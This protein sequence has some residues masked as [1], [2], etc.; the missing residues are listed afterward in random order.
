MR[1]WKNVL[2]VGEFPNV[3][4]R[5]FE[6]IMWDALSNVA[7]E[8]L[9]MGFGGFAA[10]G[11]ALS[12]LPRTRFMQ[13]K[14]LESALTN[15]CI[16]RREKEKQ[17]VHISSHFRA[18]PMK[19]IFKIELIT[20]LFPFSEMAIGKSTATSAEQFPVVKE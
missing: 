12:F 5:N 10:V 20:M 13:I 6:R 2:F 3:C 18:L 19:G 1:V 15:R 8:Q 16:H 9:K 14:R 4:K 7:P 11:L 17:N